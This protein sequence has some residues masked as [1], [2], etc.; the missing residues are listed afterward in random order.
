MYY[1]TFDVTDLTWNRTYT[2]PNADG[3]VCLD[4]GSCDSTT[5]D[6]L[7]STA[8]LRSNASDTFEGDAGR[9]LTIQSSL[10]GGVRAVDLL[11]IT[12][13]NDATYSSTG[14]MV[15]I[16]QLDTASSS[17]GM[18]IENLGIGNSIT[19]YD[20]SG[21]TTPVIIDSSGNV[22]I[23][24][25]TTSGALS[26]T[27]SSGYSIYSTTAANAFLYDTYIGSTS[28]TVAELVMNGNDLFVSG[29]IGS[30]GK[31]YSD[32]GFDAGNSILS[33]D[34]LT[35]SSTLSLVSTANNVNIKP[36]NDADDYLYVSTG[37]EVPSSDASAL[38]WEGV[39]TYT[40]DPGISV[41]AGG[42][43][44]YRDEDSS[45][46]VSLDSLNVA[47]T[48]DL[49]VAYTNDL[50][51]QLDIGS[52]GLAFDLNSTADYTIEDNG[53]AYFRF[54][55][56][57]N[58]TYTANSSKFY[59][60][61]AT[62]DLAHTSGL[63][64]MD[65][66]TGTNGASAINVDFESML[67]NSAGT[68][69]V[70]GMYLR[71][72]K[73]N[74]G[75]GTHVTEAI[76]I[77]SP[78]T[79]ICGGICQEYGIRVD[80]GYLY[81]GYFDSNV[82]IPEYGL[83]LGSTE[84]LAT[85]TEL[86][87]L[88]G[89]TATNSIIYGNGAGLDNT[90]A[91]ASGQ[92][93]V[94][95]V[96][97]VPAFVDMSGDVT[98]D[99][100]GVATVVNDSHTHG[101]SSVTMTLND[102]YTDGNSISMAGGVDTVLNL[103][104]NIGH[105]LYVDANETY[106]YTDGILFASSGTSAV[107]TDAIDVSDID[108]VYAIN[109]GNNIVKGTTGTIDFTDFDVNSD[110]AITLA[111]DLDA[112]TLQ[113]VPSI[114]LT[115]AVD[116]SSANIINALSLG[117]SNIVGTTGLIN[118]T[119]FDVDASGNVSA[120]AFAS[121]SGS[122]FNL[123]ASASNKVTVDANSASLSYLDGISFASTGASATLE[124][125][126]DASD[127]DI[128]NAINV[129]D[130]IVKGG[131]GTIDFTD[132]DVDADG[133]IVLSPDASSTG[134][135]IAP[136]GS[137]ATALDLD[138]ALIATAMSVGAND[139]VGTTG[140]I[141]YTYFDVDASGNVLTNGSIT[142]GTSITSGIAGAFNVNQYG[143]ITQ[144]S[145]G[146]DN[147]STDLINLYSDVGTLNGSDVY[148]GLQV[149]M[150]GNTGHTGVSN[151]LYGVNID[152]IT[153]VANITETAIAIGDGWEK[154][155]DLGNNSLV[156]TTGSI[157]FTNFD[158]DSS[159]NLDAA[160]R[161]AFGASGA[162]T[163]ASRILHIAD[164]TASA[165]V[166]TGIDLDL[167]SAV[168]TTYGLDITNASTGTNSYGGYIVASSATNNYG[169][170]ID[171]A[172]GSTNYALYTEDGRVR[173]GTG[174]TV[175]IADASTE[176]F[177]QG[178]IETD[179]NLLVGNSGGT[180]GIMSAASTFFINVN[181]TT[182][183]GSANGKLV[184]GAGNAVSGNGDD[185]EV[186]DGYLQVCD[187]TGTSGNC[188]SVTGFT[189]NDGDL[190]VENVLMVGY[191]GSA[192]GIGVADGGIC[193]D[194]DGGC[195]PTAVTDGNI[196]YLGQDSGHSDVA[197]VYGSNELLQE[198]DVVVI[199]VT[200]NGKVRKSSSAYE[201]GMISAVS[202]APGS[203]FGSADQE[204][205]TAAGVDIYAPGIFGGFHFLPNTYPIALAGRV[206]VKVNTENGAIQVGDLITSSQTAGV[207]MKS[208][209]PGAVIGK[210]LEPWAG[211]GQGMIEV[212][213]MPGWNSAGMIATDG[214]VST[215][216]DNFALSAT[217]T[218]DALTTGRD[219]FELAFSGSGW[220]GASA[221]QKEFT[222]KNVVTD[223]SNSK[224]SIQDETSTEVAYIDETGTMMLAG[225][226]VVTGRM[227]PSDRGVAQTNRYIYYD[228][229]DD[230]VRTNAAGWSVGSYDFAEMF[231][232]DEHLE[233][234]DIVEFT[235]NGE[236]VGK[237]AGE[238]SLTL[239]GIVS[240]R[241]GF[242]AGTSGPGKY[243]VALAGRVPT[244][245]NLEGGA[246]KVGD[247]LTSSSV[248]GIAMKARSRGPVVGYALEPYNGSNAN[249]KILAYVNVSYYAGPDFKPN[250]ADNTAS[251]APAVQTTVV[252]STSPDGD[253]Y[254]NSYDILNI[255]AIAGFGGWSIA[256][257]GT[258]ITSK[259]YEV[260]IIS[261]Q[262]EEVATHAALSTQHKI[263]LSGE[264]KLSAG[265]GTVDFELVDPKFNDV[266]STIAPI[267]VIVTLT[268]QANGIFVDTKGPQGFRVVET[269][270]GASDATFD[271]YVEAYR[272]GYEPAEEL[273][274]DIPV[275]PETTAT[276]AVAP[277]DGVLAS[278]PLVTEPIADATT[279]VPADVIADPI[280]PESS[281]ATDSTNITDTSTVPQDTT[282]TTDTS[283]AP[284]TTVLSTT[285]TE[286]AV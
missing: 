65:I 9:A 230:Y 166:A 155:I 277:A 196:K 146:V 19:V 259:S 25:A 281:V 231:P 221:V 144:N 248:F 198:G 157:D 233:P 204:E 97:N 28:A 192:S 134:F 58:I 275:A 70:Y 36:D 278:D 264:G 265:I 282:V 22:A 88:D 41:N 169:L 147:A 81:G 238:Y 179:G 112:V 152:A 4:G 214:T 80:S 43:I 173:F 129:G 72:T 33:S 66:D 210:A 60:D 175:S 107:I 140:L 272:T 124:D 31:I 270:A 95:N 262:N 211:P 184:I 114:A 93:L 163:T 46:W 279:V 245:V 191:S 61:G 73:N 268:S 126:V 63:L 68:E 258:V 91:V 162:A 108:I 261:H 202:T 105:A 253:L 53:T 6:T 193:I 194:D 228:S 5:L 235:G 137:L 127:A 2:F 251:Q 32:T 154:G 246:I 223:A 217:G 226:L 89:L 176:L 59:I 121:T 118:Y 240:T 132:F 44:V 267:R 200:E 98:I 286:P 269:S 119:Y 74:T 40:N 55:N 229:T 75:L 122:A 273:I 177:V 209:K 158:V 189:I 161:G 18:Y 128:I 225:D 135:Q 207:A 257:D 110:G 143:F 94:G 10:S 274:I 56:D 190:Q 125:A 260:K 244:K 42:E 104:N 138:D 150:Y 37:A 67:S 51:K 242:L 62:N 69:Y 237:T 35:S 82:R 186:S 109:V 160:S 21:D 23:G 17:A 1:G 172:T 205:L 136:G 224:L 103:G 76:R 215:L 106:T 54:A 20:S 131:A 212:F 271:W 12:Q 188:N 234:G 78:V 232:S 218:A 123:G 174:G 141:N 263:T 252:S 115:T 49:D 90:N 170:Y 241:P 183:T 148:A 145:T 14:D 133:A 92:I 255:G 57:K 222:I 219:S 120:N 52:S 227:F 45:S 201:S 47:S 206:P 178:D 203:L 64:D 86:N 280:A 208:T 156:G 99:N 85:A 13:A 11:N 284:D 8:F 167:T 182:P 153:S 87:L 213:I 96:S 39:S 102:S 113:I 165:T 256:E 180:P 111:P 116:L 83:Y 101:T 149:S 285:T 130:N 15:S 79:T 181:N 249:N 151:Y 16:E 50:D 236:K 250:L 29:E 266:I 247:P 185:L 142:A 27:A 239:G 199:D 164:T 30:E 38:Y 139:I 100:T 216:N 171:T 48:V 3:S 187:G 7:D 220:D 195:D 283:T 117:D 159:G 168:A 84:V 26:V 197:E 34:A 71:P 254:M 24:T 243:P 77:A 276:D